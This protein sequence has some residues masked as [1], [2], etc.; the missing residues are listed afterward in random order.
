MPEDS[1]ISFRGYV[2]DTSRTAIP[3]RCRESLFLK[4]FKLSKYLKQ[5]VLSHNL[6]AELN[7]LI[8]L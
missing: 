7:G 2:Y 1:G 8:K 6:N 5:F 4:R 3:G